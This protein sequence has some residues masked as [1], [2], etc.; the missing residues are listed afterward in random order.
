MASDRGATLLGDC[1]SIQFVS[2]PP[3]VAPSITM[4]TPA[5]Q[6]L[7]S[8]TAASQHLYTLQFKNGQVLKHQ[9]LLALS[10]FRSDGRLAAVVCE[11]PPV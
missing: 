11:Q 4:T 7:R 10:Q 2:T 3:T 8:A 1:L 9:D 6:T 5:S